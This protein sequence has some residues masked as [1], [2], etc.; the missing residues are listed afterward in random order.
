M[1]LSYVVV[2]SVIARVSWWERGLAGPNSAILLLCSRVRRQTSAASRSQSPQ[3]L[4][5]DCNFD[6]GPVE[7]KKKVRH[8]FKFTNIGGGTLTLTAGG[9]TCYG[10]HRFAVVENPARARRDGRR[11]DRI[12]Q[13]QFQGADF[14][15]RR[16]ST[17]NDPEQRRVE[18]YIFGSVISK[19]MV[20]P[21]QLVFSKISVNETKTAEVKIYSSMSD[22]VQVIKHE[23]TGADTAPFFEVHTAPIPKDELA[24]KPDVKSGCLRYGDRQT[25][26]ALGSDS[27]DNPARVERARR[28]AARHSRSGGCRQRYFHRGRQRLA[29][30]CFEA[31]HRPRPQQPKGQ[32]AS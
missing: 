22:D 21:D 24:E 19:Y 26:V 7:R 11:D 5:D 8:T 31:D 27:A 28:R 12:R 15:S 32:P 13:H 1:K 2:V 20:V 9:T 30:R 16:R 3:V 10:V 25:G 6:F 14:S 29:R 17:T 4:V 23:L 18:L